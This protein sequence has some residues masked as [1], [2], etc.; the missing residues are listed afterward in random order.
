MNVPTSVIFQ[1]QNSERLMAFGGLSTG[2]GGSQPLRTPLVTLDEENAK[3]VIQIWQALQASPNAELLRIP[4][5]RWETSLSRRDLEDKLIDVWISLESLLQ[6][7]KELSFRAALR[8]A[9]F[10]GTSGPHKKKDIYD[11]TKLS[12]DWR[13][14]IV[15]GGKTKKL[16]NRQS[17]EETVQ[18]TTDWIREALLKVLAL[19]TQFNPRDL[20]IRLLNRETG[21][22]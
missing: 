5:R 6:I 20:E 11:K 7:D 21:V 1:Q 8:L 4:L 13:S 16:A 2:Y 17:L 3:Q 12:Y 18:L 19:N 14:A 15:H 22:L 10:L 9:E